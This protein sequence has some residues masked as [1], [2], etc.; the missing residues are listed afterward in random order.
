MIYLF[1]VAGL[2]GFG[3]LLGSYSYSTGFSSCG[4]TFY[5][6]YRFSF[7]SL[8]CTS[9]DYGFGSFTLEGSN[10]KL[11]FEEDTSD[12]SE[13]IYK[14]E[15]T[16]IK[17]DKI[18]IDAQLLDFNTNLPEYGS[19][20]LMTQFDSVLVGDICDSNGNVH[21]ELD[22]VKSAIKFKTFFIGYKNVTHFLEIGKQYKIIQYLVDNGTLGGSIEGGT[23][24]EFTIDRLT[25][26]YIELTFHYTENERTSTSRYFKRK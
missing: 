1:F 19:I 14:V 18:I 11:Y 26:K 22:M 16:N 7:S 13:K 3:Q 6:G 5:E 8:S 4:I 15:S 25:K 23:I 2:Q 9:R 12:F 21:L 10:L 17:A 24:Y 20:C